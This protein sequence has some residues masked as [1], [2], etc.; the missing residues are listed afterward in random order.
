[1]P[2]YPGLVL[3]HMEAPDWWGL[4][5]VRPYERVVF[6]DNGKATKVLEGGRHDVAR[7]PVIGVVDVIWVAMKNFRAGF[8]TQ[9]YSQESVGTKFWGFTVLKVVDVEA[10]V[11][12]VVGAQRVYTQDDLSEWIRGQIVSVVRSRAAGG[13]WS[14]YVKNRGAFI[15]QVR[16]QIGPVFTEYGLE[17][18]TVEIENIEI[19]KELEEA[20]KRET[21]SGFEAEALRKKGAAAASVYNEIRKAGV[22]PA[23]IE[24][25][26]SLTGRDMSEVFYNLGVSPADVASRMSGQATNAGLLGG[27]G[28]GVSKMGPVDLMFSLFA[29][30]MVQDMSG[31]SAQPPPVAPQAGQ[32]NGGA[33]RSAARCARCGQDLPVGANFCS[34]C[35]EPAAPGGKCA[36]CG[37]E[38]LRGAS[39]CQQ[40]GKPAQR[41]GSAQQ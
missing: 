14:D 30:K 37:A 12:N 21:A 11:N 2:E 13:P 6:L 8:F 36:S 35:G 16:D 17:L 24:F 25:F 26:K 28:L 10:F 40:C 3:Y 31:L 38:L 39:F 41:P 4:Y 32:A 34:I 23:T 33:F 7:F 1:M 5:L 9:A 15:D 29:M 18:T 27:G 20:V 22:N 19:P